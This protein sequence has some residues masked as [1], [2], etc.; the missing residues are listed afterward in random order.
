MSPKKAEK[1]QDALCIK[2]F[3][4]NAE[5]QKTPAECRLHLPLKFLL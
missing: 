1:P 5:S 2:V 4:I 3:S